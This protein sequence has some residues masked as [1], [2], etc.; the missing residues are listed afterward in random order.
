MHVH[1]AITGKVNKMILIS[2][3]D[4]VQ[5]GRVADSEVGWLTKKILETIRDAI[6]EDV[7]RIV[8]EMK[9]VEE[10]ESLST[11]RVDEWSHGNVSSADK[12]DEMA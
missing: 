4:K 5:E 7:S 6:R 10:E 9:K 8:K 1:L 2:V 11:F 3:V 12:D